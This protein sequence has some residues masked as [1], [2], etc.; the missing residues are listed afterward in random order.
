[1]RWSARFRTP[2]RAAAFRRPGCSRACAGSAR[3]RRRVSWRARSITNWRTARSPARR[4]T[5]RFS[6]YTARRSWRAGISTSSRWT[7]PRTTASRMSARSTMRSATRRS[8]RATRSTS[9]T[10]CTCFRAPPSMHSSRRWKSR[11]RTP[12]SCSPRRKSARSPLLSFRAASGSIFGGSTRR[13]WSS[14]W[15]ASPARKRSPPSRK[16]WG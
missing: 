4:S 11:R 6:A 2:S 1:M 15:Q 13:F 8:R 10:K 3:P 5:C 14:I 7:R 16:R 9:S 12:S